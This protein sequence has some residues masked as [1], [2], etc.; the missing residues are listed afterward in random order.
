MCFG[1]THY[2]SS[3]LFTV[4]SHTLHSIPSRCL[5]HFVL[6]RSLSF[7]WSSVCRLFIYF[8]YHHFSR[9]LNTA[10][11]A[12]LISFSFVGYRFCGHVYVLRIQLF[13]LFSSFFFHSHYTHVALD[14]VKLLSSLRSHSKVIISL[15]RTERVKGLTT[16]TKREPNH[17][18]NHRLSLHRLLL[19]G[20]VSS[21]LLLGL[22]CLG[23]T[24]N[25]ERMTTNT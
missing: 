21:T 7:L 2:F 23:L 3:F 19:L 20:C 4:T 11:V 14:A 6:I 13:T 12:F 8:C 17:Q 9:S 16:N 22:P 10:Q 18:T 24:Q 5:I 1:F 15:P 25:E